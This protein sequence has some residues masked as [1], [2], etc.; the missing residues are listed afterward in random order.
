MLSHCTP[1]TAGQRDVTLVPEKTNQ[2]V[3][4]KYVWLLD[5]TDFPEVPSTS[6]DDEVVTSISPTTAASTPGT[7][8]PFWPGSTLLEAGL[9]STISHRVPE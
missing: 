4:A 1:S 9:Y 6:L 8:S 5:L 3:L 2:V 7:P